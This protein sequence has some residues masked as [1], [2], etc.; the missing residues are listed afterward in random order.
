MKQTY[1]T[2]KGIKSLVYQTMIER[3]NPQNA[4]DLF[5]IAFMLGMFQE[6]QQSKVGSLVKLLEILT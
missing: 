1:I 6:K 2:N 3:M 5:K 4:N